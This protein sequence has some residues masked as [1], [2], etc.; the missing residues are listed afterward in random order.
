M[1]HL[2]YTAIPSIAKM[3]PLILHTQILDPKNKRSQIL[4]WQGM[5]LL[6]LSWLDGG[7]KDLRTLNACY[8]Y[9]LFFLAPRW[10]ALTSINLDAGHKNARHKNADSIYK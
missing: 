9:T 6:L 3:S 5:Q 10:R 1:G 2:I 4:S 8:I 7:I